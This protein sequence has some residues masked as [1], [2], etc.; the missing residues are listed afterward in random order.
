MPP[1]RCRLPIQV[2]MLAQVTEPTGRSES[3]QQAPLLVLDTNIVLD[4]LVFA[5][6]RTEP[7]RQAL[8]AGHAHW[9]ATAHM[10]EELSR[11]L[12][13]THVQALMHSRERE[14]AQV[15]HGFDAA[16][17]II[18]EAPAKAPYTCK[19]PD[20]QVFIDLACHLAQRDGAGPVRLISK[21]KAVL[22]LRKRLERCAVFVS[23]TF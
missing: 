5:D 11:V 1:R 7:L 4:L 19:D 13:Y 10:R 23:V 9:Y 17:H 22:C 21:D 6:P 14:A 12:A 2:A 3:A 18:A 16:A 8:Q 15:L 20:D